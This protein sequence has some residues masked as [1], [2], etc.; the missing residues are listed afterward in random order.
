M[1]CR[2]PRPC[3]C[4]P[5][6]GRSSRP[7]RRP[8]S[9]RGSRLPDSVRGRRPRQTEGS[10]WRPARSG[11]PRRRGSPPTSAVWAGALTRSRPSARRDQWPPERTRVR[12]GS[13][14]AW[15]RRMAACTTPTASIIT[16]STQCGRSQLK[17]SSLP[18][19]G[20]PGRP[21]SASRAPIRAR[22]AEVG[23]GGQTSLSSCDQ[24]G[25]GGKHQQDLQLT[26]PKGQ[27][28]SQG[29]S[30]VWE[31]KQQHPGSSWPERP[32]QIKCQVGLWATPG[33]SRPPGSAA[34]FL[35]QAD[36]RAQCQLLIVLLQLHAG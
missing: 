9:P 33:R 25:P 18:P 19:S 21:T 11:Q 17:R 5:S 29:T 31:D 1:R 27:P 3:G 20:P 36:L 34:A 30:T 7:A 22:G 24:H 35:E 16:R 6:R 4:R 2:R 10:S 13:R 12:T 23:C 32:R 8:R 26:E 28:D 15:S 14:I